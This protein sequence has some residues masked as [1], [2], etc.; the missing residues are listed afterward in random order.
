MPDLPTDQSGFTNASGSGVMGAV[1]VNAGNY[2]FSISVW[3]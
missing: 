2:A 3:S 1:F